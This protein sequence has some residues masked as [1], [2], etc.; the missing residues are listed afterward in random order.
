MSL[1]LLHQMLASDVRHVRAGVIAFNAAL[2]ACRNG[3]EWQ[4][5]VHVLG[6]MC[7]TL[8]QPDSSTATTVL[9]ACERGGRPDVAL[10]LWREFCEAHKIERIQSTPAYNAAIRAAYR[11][12]RWQLAVHFFHEMHTLQ[13]ESDSYSCL[14]AVYACENA[15]QWRLGAQILSAHGFSLHRASL[16]KTA[17]RLEQQLTNELPGQ[18]ASPN[19]LLDTKVRVKTPMLLA[20]EL[21]SVPL[22]T[23]I[24][25]SL[26]PLQEVLGQ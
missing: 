15:G 10:D 13:I 5:A 26:E 22:P 2:L 17:L 7:S 12:S 3:S 19:P 6:S 11:A 4:F 9:A 21:L 14:L 18:H 16:E 25:P 23:A 8:L 20:G 1:A 24:V